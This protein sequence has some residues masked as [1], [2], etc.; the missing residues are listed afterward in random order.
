MKDLALPGWGN[1]REQNH[2]A[3]ITGVQFV[4]HVFFY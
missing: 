4:R 3:V 2:V 1:L